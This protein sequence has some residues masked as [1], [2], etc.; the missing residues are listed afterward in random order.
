MY[1]SLTKYECVST[2]P[3]AKMTQSHIRHIIIGDTQHKNNT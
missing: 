3:S 1:I 2:V